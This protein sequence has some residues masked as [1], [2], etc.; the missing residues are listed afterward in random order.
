[1][2]AMMYP[3]VNEIEKELMETNE[4]ILRA[5]KMDLEDLADDDDDDLMM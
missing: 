5:Q 3:D 1:V 4:E 2:K